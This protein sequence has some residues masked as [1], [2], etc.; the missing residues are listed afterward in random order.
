M[1]ASE[2]LAIVR[3]WID[4]YNKHRIAEAEKLFTED[5]VHYWIPDEIVKR[6]RKEIGDG[7]RQVNKGFPDLI[8]RITNHVVEGNQVVI[9]VSWKGTFT[10]EFLGTKPTGKKLNLPAI[11]VVEF[12]GRKIKTV[13]EYYPS[14]LLTKQLG[15]Q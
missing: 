13:R 9:E 2:N 11:F 3:K 8:T 7:M 14:G 5:A 15:I 10:G 12:G 1:S 6:G 4:C